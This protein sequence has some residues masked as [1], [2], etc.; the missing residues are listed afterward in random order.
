MS[1]LK[2]IYAAAV[3]VTLVTGAQAGPLEDA[4]KA[5]VKAFYEMAFRDRQPTKA[6]QTYIGDRYIQ[7]NPRVPNGAAAFYGF[8]E[9]YL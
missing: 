4:N 2:Y 6:A 8:F 9:N 3:S 7:H 5:I 1:L